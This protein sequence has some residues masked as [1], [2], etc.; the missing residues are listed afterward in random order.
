MELY[1]NLLTEWHD[2]DSAQKKIERLLWIADDNLIFIRLDDDCALPFQRSRLELE[3]AFQ[4]GDF[5]ILDHDPYSTRQRGDEDLSDAYRKRRDSAWEAIAPLVSEADGKVFRAELRGRM[6]VEAVKRTGKTKRMIYIYLR[7]FWQGG[8][9]KNSLLP[10]YDRCGAIGQEKGFSEIKRGRPHAINGKGYGTNINKEHR[11]NFRRAIKLHYETRNGSH[12]RTLCDAYQFALE[13]FYSRGHDLR[14]GVWTPVLPPADELPSFRQFQYWYQKERDPRRSHI[15]REGERNYHLKHREIL[16]DSSKMAFGPGSLYQLDST[17]ADIHLVYSFNRAR[18][19][20]RPTLYLVVD[21]FTRLIAGFCVTLEK[22]SYLGAMLALQNATE[23]KVE[24]CAKNGVKITAEE[25][26]NQHLPEAILADRAEL[27][28]PKSDSLVTGLNITIN[29]TAPYRADMKGIV[30]RSFRTCNDMVIHW[31]DGA[32]TPVQVRGEPDSRLKA[33]LNLYEFRQLM[34]HSILHHNR[35]LI[36]GFRRQQFMIEHDVEC[37]P[38]D[39]WKWGI[40]NRSG[41]LRKMDR[42]VLWFYLL[43][44]GEASVTHRGIRLNGLHYTCERAVK[45][46]WFGRA[47]EKR[48]WKVDVTYDPRYVGVIYLFVKGAAEPEPCVLVDAD[49]RFKDRALEE[50]QDSI[51]LQRERKEASR[52]NDQQAAA[53]FHAQIE[54]ITDEARV[55]TKTACKGLSK[56]QLLENCR[57]NRTS[58]LNSERQKGVPQVTPGTELLTSAD[59]PINSNEEY[60]PPPSLSEILGKSQIEESKDQQDKL[61]NT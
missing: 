21:V 36:G 6:V 32:S 34:I 40:R 35:S 29:N 26:P 18:K 47:R 33:T 5:H 20:G 54:N 51:E 25:W 52:S 60:I 22:P 41:H 57:E 11:S 30:E 38:V 39:I 59:A 55:Q 14:R 45:E 24:F 7:R 31:L 17:I 53:N 50:L 28:G 3:S 61:K 42:G 13:R 43:P 19:I 48:S 4:A 9:T 44:K 58:E 15:A 1:T 10:Y 56:Q 23:D 16:G 37:R 49:A 27:L 46:Q 12:K 2:N 8:Q